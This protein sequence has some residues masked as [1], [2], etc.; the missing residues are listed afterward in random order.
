MRL[1][2]RAELFPLI[3]HVVVEWLLQGFSE[4]ALSL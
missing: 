2:L 1:I 4:E 3:D